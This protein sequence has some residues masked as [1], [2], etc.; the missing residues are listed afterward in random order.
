MDWNKGFSAIYEL[1]KIDPVSWLDTGSFDLTGGN[2]SKTDD[3]LQESATIQM[4]ENPRECWLRVYLKAKQGQSGARIPLFTGL[5]STPQ[6]ELDGRRESFQTVCY[7]VLKP[8]DDVLVTPGYYV[9]VG[10]EGAR[11]AAQLL[12]VGP[13]PVSFIEGGPNLI[14]P[15]VAEED[16]TH[17]SIVQ[18]IVK[19]IGWRIRI[20]GDGSISI[21]PFAAEDSI[22]LDTMENDSIELRITD[23]QDWYS[24]PN[25]YR[26]ST[27]SM[28]AVARDDDPESPLSTVSRKKTRGGTG[29]I[30]TSESSVT[31]GSGESLAEYAMRKLQ[32]AQAPARKINYTRRFQPDVTV[33]DLVRLHL[34]G[35]GIDGSFRVSKQ[36]IELGHGARTQEEVVMV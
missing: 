36:N 17:L 28:Y 2:I 22:Q 4:R 25:C 6:R 5:A 33:G 20:R 30:W 26:V 35:Q 7:S 12:R 24:V 10:A 3:N 1:K 16:D 21:E 9:P 8:P 13:A 23:S 19:A 11:V 32:E 31:L 15:I 34:P 18:Q 29:E 27:G 14:E